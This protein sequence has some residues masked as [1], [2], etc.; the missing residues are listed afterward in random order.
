MDIMK[1]NGFKPANERSRT[2][3]AQII[4]DMDHADDIGLLANT[5]DQVE[6]LLHSL[7]LAASSTGVYVNKTEHMCL[8]PRG[9]ISKLKGCLLKWEDNII[10]SSVS[11]SEIDNNTRWAETWTAMDWLSVK[12]KSD[13]TDKIKRSFFFLSSSRVDTAIWMDIMDAK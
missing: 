1:D 6:S 10:E 2:Y 13:L 3:P 7:Q 8:D 4:T 5:P 9:N 11:S 12:F